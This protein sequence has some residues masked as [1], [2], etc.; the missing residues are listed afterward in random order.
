MNTACH[1]QVV[2][3]YSICGGSTSVLCGQL[4][5]VIVRA[6]VCMNRSVGKETDWALAAIVVISNSCPLPIQPFIQTC[7][8]CATRPFPE[9]PHWERAREAI[10]HRRVGER[11]KEKRPLMSFIFSNLYL[12]PSPPPLPC[13]YV[14]MCLI[15]P[16]RDM[17]RRTHMLTHAC[18]QIHTLIITLRDMSTLSLFSR[19]LLEAFMHIKQT[20][21][22]F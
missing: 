10:E 1:A 7:L 9:D 2:S 17:S 13:C 20:L 18:K 12:H 14:L 22:P 5:V 3:A 21:F 6:C 15:I 8:H 4:I 19:G 11:E 16:L